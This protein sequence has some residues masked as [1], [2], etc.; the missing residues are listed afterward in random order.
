MAMTERKTRFAPAG[1]SFDLP[2]LEHEV[3]E[4]WERE[5][6]FDV[7]REKNAGH[8]RFSFID[9]PIT[10]N[11]E[12]MGIHHAWARTYKDVFQRFKAMEGYEQRYQNGFDC[13]GLWVEVGVERDL[14]IENKREI[15]RYGVAKFNAAC[16][17]RVDRSAAAFSMQSARLGQWMDWA[18]SYY[19]YTDNN[20]SHIWQTLKMCH[21]RGWLY[22]GHRSMPWCARCGTALSQHELA[23]GY[24][25]MTH[26]SVY[27]RFPIEGRDGES[28]LVW[29]T[30]P[31]TLPANVALAVHPGLEYVRVKDGDEV[32][33][34]G[35]KVYE[36]MRW[37]GASVL[38]TVKGRDL[39]GLRFRGPF[40][41][42]LPATADSA[43]AH[44]VIP[45]NEVGE[46]EGTGIV[47]IAPGCGEEDF[48]LSKEHDLP[49]LVPIDDM[50]RFR[51]GYGWLEGKDARDVGDE[52]AGDLKKR[53]LLFRS[54]PYT[55]RYPECWRCH[56]ELVFR[57]DDE[58]FISMAEL[59]PKMIAAARKV[60]WVPEHAGK[61]M[62]NWLQ[63]MAD[64]NISRKRYWG[65]PLPFYTC[66]NGHFFVVGSEAELRKLA[67]SGLDR[68][69]ELHRPWIDQVVVGCPQCR[70]DATRVKEVG[71]CW[72]DAGV[73]PFS[74]LGYQ[75]NSPEWKKWFPADYVV[76]MVEQ[77]RLWFY[78]LLFFSVVHT[79]EA[80]YKVVQTFE[81]MLDESGGEFHKTGE[82]MVLLEEVMEKVGADAIRWTV[83]RQR[84]DETMLFSLKALDEIKRRLLVLWNTYSFF[85]TYAELNGF[86]P[87]QPKV[88]V[89]D[90]P[91]MDRWLLS[92]L[93]RLARDGRRALEDWDV[94]TLTLRVEGF[95]ED[96]SQWYVRRSRPR[97]W[98][99]RDTR[100]TLAAQQT[101]DEALTTVTR[102]IAPVM[103]FFS[104]SLYQR[105][106]RAVSPNAEASVHHTSYPE[107]DPTLVDDDLERRMEAVRRI[108]TLAHSARQTANVKTRMPLARLVAVFDPT[109]HDRDLLAG[110]A[111]LVDIVKDELN[112]KAFEIRD[113]AEGLVRETVKPELKALGPKLGKDLPRVRAALAEGRYERRDGTYLVE[114]HT[115][116]ASEVLVSH[117]GTA[118]HAVGRDAGLVVALDTHTTPELEAEGL[119][120]E[121]IRRVNEMRKD[122][123]LQISDRIALRYGGALAAAIA[124]H[125]DLVASETLATSVTSGLTDH[126]YRWAG[127]LN[128][129]KVE[130]E[131]E[132]V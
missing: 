36:G 17:A 28:V 48:A 60:R 11:A 110:Q 89:A 104:E 59:R 124:R 5:K 92:V 113:D 120:R 63:N 46:E 107:A 40:D 55:H 43:P 69:H 123:H 23:L 125:G 102:L 79:G 74:T 68:L 27:V 6:S 32:L 51:P 67:K 94:R 64:W 12:A 128:G 88:P 42:E 19:T 9:G 129:V 111:E 41:G 99:T 8:P 16:R 82:N 45:W 24:R 122:A 71:D 18:D 78:S 126:G 98:G 7:L 13:H 108:V 93:H 44:K 26:T 130:L 106:V 52:I 114:G 37:A 10:A 100:S 85:A 75:Q 132:K 30:T 2:E 35:K 81:P 4:L 87:A 119:A 58:W 31:W 95:V 96:L 34:L 112:V 73:V 38:E 39:L 118:G 70:A 116:Q 20:I 105:L 65:L 57:V 101:L 86:D 22:K 66:A 91:L 84:A 33:V 50:A 77:V 62:E 49:V 97:F 21:E 15:E 83:S 76:E 131:I 14:L 72:L 115:L 80:P 127:E 25:D 103:P 47:H 117:E 1:S 90:R 121:L 54:A 56:E 109:D 61:R 53:G 3:L 29:T